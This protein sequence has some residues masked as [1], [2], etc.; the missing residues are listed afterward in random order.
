[1]QMKPFKA[2]C[3]K[4]WKQ[5]CARKKQVL[6]NSMGN[7]IFIGM[8]GVI[9]ILGLR[10]SGT[11]TKD[12][13]TRLVIYVSIMC[14][15]MA[16]LALLR[17]WQEKSNKTIETLIAMPIGTSMIVIAKTLVPVM[18]ACVIGAIDTTILT[19][20]LFGLYGEMMVSYGYVLLIQLL[21]TL[22]IGMPY[23]IINAYS[24]WCMDIAFSKFLQGIS[25]YAYGGILA[26]MFMSEAASPAALIQVIVCCGV[27]L[28]IVAFS[29][30][31]RFNKE[32]I[33]VRLLD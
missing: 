7:F 22:L 8:I 27:V 18:G 10:S 11:D 14:S 29:L 31:P 16:L 15:Y 30:L 3:W 6:V 17:F 23:G 9:K 25:T 26:Y 19:L 24:M 4:E 33:V 2:V 5:I 13:V 12:A 32:K 28:S 21:F 1:M 20:V